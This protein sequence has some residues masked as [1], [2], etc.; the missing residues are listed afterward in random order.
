MSNA[1][2]AAATKT[3]ESTSHARVQALREA[4]VISGIHA[5][6]DTTAIGRPLQAL[7]FVR[8]HPGS[9]EELQPE[10]ERLAKLPAVL[11]V[12]F[13]G[14]HYDFVLWVAASNPTEL[15]AFVLHDLSE[16]RAIAST[17]TSVILDHQRGTDFNAQFEQD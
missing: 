1:A 13:L 5:E 8:I 6:V 3:A 9:R 2:L 15:R 16:H 10:T 11:N 7:I 12:F 14:G 17:E 4:G